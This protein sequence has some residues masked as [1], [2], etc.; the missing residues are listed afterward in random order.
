MITFDFNVSS[1]QKVHFLFIGQINFDDSSTLSSNIVVKF[2]LSSNTL[3]Y[4]RNYIRRYNTVVPG[5]L[6][7][8]VSL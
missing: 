6:L 4:L 7:M 3:Y 8:S 2:M 5:D 1:G